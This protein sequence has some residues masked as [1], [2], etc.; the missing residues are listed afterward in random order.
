MTT[1]ENT[2]FSIKEEDIHNPLYNM[3]NSTT[4]TTSTNHYTGHGGSSRN[5]ITG[6]AGGP[7]GGTANDSLEVQL[8][9]PLPSYMMHAANGDV[10]QPAQASDMSRLG[11]GGM[12]GLELGLESVQG[13]MWGDQTAARTQ[14]MAAG[15][16]MGFED[17]FGD[18]WKVWGNGA[19][20]G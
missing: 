1:L 2:S 6:F 20:G 11:M 19:Y 14:A 7:P 8:F 12:A 3:N 18:D 13:G 15:M 17:V 10:S 5:S 4:P 9:G 16:A